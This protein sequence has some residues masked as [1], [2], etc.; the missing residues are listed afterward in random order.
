MCEMFFF[1]W[2]LIFVMVWFLGGPELQET[3]TTSLGVKQVF[4]GTSTGKLKNNKVQTKESKT[5]T[6][7]KNR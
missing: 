6:G 4:K 3:E 7:K 2:L 5:V 1:L